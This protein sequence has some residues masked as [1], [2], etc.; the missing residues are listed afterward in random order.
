MDRDSA[1]APPITQEHWS[2]YFDDSFTLNGAG[3]GVVLVSPKGDRLLYIIRLHFCGTN[4]VVEYEVLVNGM[5]IDA[6]LRVER[7]Y[8]HG[9]SM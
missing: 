7:L 4:N 1:A 5:C 6:K 8:I 3:G 9:D 2:M